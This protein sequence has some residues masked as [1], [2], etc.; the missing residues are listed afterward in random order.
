MKADKNATSAALHGI[1]SP[2]QATVPPLLLGVFVP[3]ELVEFDGV[4]SLASP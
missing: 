1:P 3:H 4:H 2:Q